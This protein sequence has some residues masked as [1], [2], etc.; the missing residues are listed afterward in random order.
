MGR[1][2]GGI[3]CVVLA[4]VL[5]VMAVGG[6]SRGP[7]VTDSSG[8]GVSHAVGAF[9]PAMIALIVGVVLLKSQGRRR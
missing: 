7:D 8:L 9:L 3:V 4:A 2:I 1:R 6:L 5:F